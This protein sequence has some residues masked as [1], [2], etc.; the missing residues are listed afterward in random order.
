MIERVVYGMAGIRIMSSALEFLGAL[1]ML[2]VGTAQKALMVNSLLALVGPF[3]LVSVTM[4][5]IAGLG[6][7]VAWWRIGVIL[8]G[9]GCIL[10]GARG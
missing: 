3:I 6:S 5:G 4:L 2:R 10:L 7:G 9:V 8:I 1:L